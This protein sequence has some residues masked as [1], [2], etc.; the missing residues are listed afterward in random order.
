VYAE[1]WKSL[2]VSRMEQLA[3]A[4]VEPAALRPG[5]AFALFGWLVR[6][7]ADASA[8]M[9]LAP[10]RAGLLE[11]AHLL[12]GSSHAA[13]RERPW[14]ALERLAARADEDRAD[15]DWR[16]VHDALFLLARVAATPTKWLPPVYRVGAPTKTTLNKDAS[17]RELVASLREHVLQA[18]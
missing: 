16:R 8:T 18:S 7:Q 3:T 14:E 9:G 17:L 10:P 6:R 13:P 15:P 1:F 12:S 2:A 5:E 4:R 11:L